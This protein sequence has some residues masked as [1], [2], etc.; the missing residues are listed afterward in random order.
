MRSAYVLNV[1]E[2]QTYLLQVT[3]LVVKRIVQFYSN[4]SL[5]ENDIQEVNP[6]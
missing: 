6:F 5:T 2:E 1:L 3:G 4:L